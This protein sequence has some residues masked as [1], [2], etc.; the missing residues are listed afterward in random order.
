MSSDVSTWYKSVPQ[1]TRYWLTATL[2]FS[3]GAKLGIIPAAYLYLDST[4]V[5]QKLQVCFD[6][7]HQVVP[8][9][10]FPN[11]LDL[12]TCNLTVLLSNGIPL[13]DELLFPLQLLVTPWERPLLGES[14]WLSLFVAIQL[15]LLCFSGIIRLVSCKS[16]IKRSSQ[17]PSTI[18]F[19]LSS[20]WIRWFSLFYM[21]GASWTKRLLSVSGLEHDLRRC[22]CL[23][24]YLALTCWCQTAPCLR[25]SASLSDIST[26]SS[27]SHIRKSSEAR[28]SWRPHRS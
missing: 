5:F 1:F 20:W 12:A 24:F 8:L 21:S 22:T 6:N 10:N 15:A 28:I 2:G 14:R 16:S 17:C 18:Y 27:S 4:F 11:I 3:V 19:L 25:S 26:F 7:D 9:N 23:G 13:P